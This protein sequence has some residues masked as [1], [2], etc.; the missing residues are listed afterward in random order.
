MST[1]DWMSIIGEGTK[2]ASG[3]LESASQYG[4]AKK[5]AKEAKRRTLANLMTSATRR[6]RNLFRKGQEYG[7]EMRDYQSQALQEVAKGFAQALQGST[8]RL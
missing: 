2:G 5:E 1:E 6:N 7:D 4:M 3:A 8:G